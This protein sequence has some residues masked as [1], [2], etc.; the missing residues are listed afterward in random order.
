VGVA[1]CLNGDST[2]DGEIHAVA[3]AE[4]T[5]EVVLP[6]LSSDKPDPGLH[7]PGGVPRE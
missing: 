1:L 7:W 4:N 3:S 2:F 5:T 6:I